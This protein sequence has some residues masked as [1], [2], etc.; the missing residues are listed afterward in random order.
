VSD[1]LLSL[2]IILAVIA[3]FGT[4]IFAVVDVVKMGLILRG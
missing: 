1:N 2:L 4:L 3:L